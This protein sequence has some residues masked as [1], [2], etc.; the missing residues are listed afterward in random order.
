[1]ETLEKPSKPSPPSSIS[2]N[3]NS[4][5]EDSISSLDKH[6]VVLKKIIIEPNAR[7]TNESKV[8]SNRVIRL[9]NDPNRFRIVNFTADKKIWR[10]KAWKNTVKDICLLGVQDEGKT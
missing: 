10:E 1:M 5:A 9:V 8:L 4:T 7:R 6:F 2:S 3:N